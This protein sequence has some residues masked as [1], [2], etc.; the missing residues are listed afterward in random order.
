MH[1]PDHQQQA[2]AYAETIR[3]CWV[4]CPQLETDRPWVRLLLC[5]CPNEV[6]HPN[7]SYLSAQKQYLAVSLCPLLE[8]IESAERF[9]LTWGLWTEAI[10]NFRTASM[11]L[12]VEFTSV[13]CHNVRY[14]FFHT[15]HMYRLHILGH[16]CEPAIRME[17]QNLFRVN[18][19]HRQLEYQIFGPLWLACSHVHHPLKVSISACHEILE[20]PD[21]AS[22]ILELYSW[23]IIGSC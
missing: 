3:I 8:D 17:Q 23:D 9:V 5:S 7:M 4:F 10:C 12:I 1:E 16:P 15:I 14:N 11:D 13:Q 6:S 20:T 19:M 18:Q 21:T 2:Y 22:H